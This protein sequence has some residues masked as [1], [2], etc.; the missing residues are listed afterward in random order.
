MPKAFPDV[1]A[2]PIVRALNLNEVFLARSALQQSIR[3]KR[4]IEAVKVVDGRIQRTVPRFVGPVQIRRLFEAGDSGWGVA[5]SRGWD[6][7]RSVSVVPRIM[8]S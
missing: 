7:T 4:A 5:G 2:I 1:P 6:E 8:H 3:I